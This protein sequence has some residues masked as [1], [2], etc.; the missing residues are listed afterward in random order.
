LA[1]V[2]PGACAMRSKRSSMAGFEDSHPVRSMG[3]AMRVE[4]TATITERVAPVDAA[5]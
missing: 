3:T 5:A 1:P 4:N 2:R